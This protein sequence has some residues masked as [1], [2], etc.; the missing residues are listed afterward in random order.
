MLA[1]LDD[2]LLHAKTES[3][4]IDTVEQLF[5]FCAEKNLKLHPAKYLL[6]ATEI[7]WCGRMISESGIRYDPHR[8]DGLLKM[9]PPFSTTNLQQ[10]TCTLQWVKN[11]IPNF[12]E[13][14][15]PLHDFMETVYA[16]TCKRT[17]LAVS[18]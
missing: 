8:L 15:P 10:F 12:T 6:F 11:G 13:L 2:I 3:G 7:Y 9:K 18:W 1:W 16:T 5:P 17:K 4:I 14:I